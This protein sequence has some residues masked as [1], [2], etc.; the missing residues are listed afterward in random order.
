MEETVLRDLRN[1][2]QDPKDCYA[3]WC[4][5]VDGDMEVTPIGF[6]AAMR[7]SERKLL[8][9]RD[10]REFQMAWARALQVTPSRTKVTAQLRA[11]SR[12]DGTVRAAILMDNANQADVYHVELE[13]EGFL[14][15]RVAHLLKTWPKPFQAMRQDRK[16]FELRKDD[17]PMKFG[18]DDELRLAQFD[19]DAGIFLGDMIVA[20]VTYISREEDWGLQPGHVVLGLTL[21]DYLPPTN[22]KA[23]MWLGCEHPG[24]N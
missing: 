7:Q 8:I 18:Y 14:H 1:A 19:P 23:T 15:E 9:F 4:V 5:I 2:L 11:I 21:Q 17:R 16:R 22:P 20:R 13:T 24:M 10:F 12:Q 6:G 3:E